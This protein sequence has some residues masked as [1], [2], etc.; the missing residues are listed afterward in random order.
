M[1]MHPYLRARTANDKLRHVPKMTR[2]VPFGNIVNITASL[3]SCWRSGGSC[4]V[5]TPAKRIPRRREIGKIEAERLRLY[6]SFDSSSVKL[7]EKAA[8]VGEGPWTLT[9]GAGGGPAKRPAVC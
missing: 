7:P 5:V 8:R 6:A 4:A 1:R 3:A 2:F 9:P